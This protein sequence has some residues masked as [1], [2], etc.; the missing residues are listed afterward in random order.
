MHRDDAAELLQREKIH[1]AIVV[2]EDG[3]F[4]GKI[5]N[6]RSDDAPPVLLPVL[7]L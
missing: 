7:I 3:K 1:H 4:V 2:G 6:Y 5:Q